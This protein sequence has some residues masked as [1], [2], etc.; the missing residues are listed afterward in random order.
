MKKIFILHGWTKSL[1]KWDKVVSRLKDKG[2]DSILLKVP[3]LTS[4]IDHVWDIDDYVS[5]LD[6][7][8]KKENGKVILLGHSNGGRISLAFALRHPDRIE[9]LILV[10]SAGVYRNELP[11]RLKRFIFGKAAKLGK[12]ITSSTSAKK[13][14]YKLARS[15]DYNDSGDLLKQTLLNLWESDK[16]RIYEKVNVPTFIIWGKKDTTTPLKDGEKI[17]HAIKNSKLFVIPEARHGPQ[18]TNAEE[19]VNIALK[20]LNK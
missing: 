3:G 4:P 20:I 18:F 1:D 17:N 13:L 12:R 19:F 9:K 15:S 5:W 7:E 11:I 6:N 8:L 16:K 2:F 10:D 14:L